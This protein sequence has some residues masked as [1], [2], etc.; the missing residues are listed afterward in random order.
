MTTWE[1]AKIH[2]TKNH[3]RGTV[4]YRNALL[5]AHTFYMTM[6]EEPEDKRA[7]DIQHDEDLELKNAILSEQQILDVFSA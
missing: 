4:A 2:F 7:S 3:E 5:R 6:V 1:R